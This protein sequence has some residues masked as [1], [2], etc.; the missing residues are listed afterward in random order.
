MS[1]SVADIR[2]NKVTTKNDGKVLH[3]FLKLVA[4]EKE[5][6]I[7][8]ITEDDQTFHIK[9]NRTKHLF[10][11]SSA[12]GFNHMILEK[13]KRFYHIRLTD[14]FNVWLIPVKFILANGFFLDF[15][16]QGFE[17]QIFVTLEQIKKFIIKS[18]T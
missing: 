2:G 14:E 10:R 5:K 1:N 18:N 13:T 11:K 12:Y 7:G 17:K 16:Q 9:R 6:N 8:F 15:L 4:E 3:V